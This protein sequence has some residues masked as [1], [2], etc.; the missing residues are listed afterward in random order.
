MNVECG[1]VPGQP[2]S[3]FLY[4]HAKHEAV[5]I[6]LAPEL[7]PAS[8]SIPGAGRAAPLRLLCLAP[9]GVC[10]AA[11]I[12]AS[13]GGLLHR[14]FT[15]TPYSRRMQYTSLLHYAVGLPR[16]SVRQHRCPL[17]SGLSST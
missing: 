3:R 1:K 8:S 2:I 16:L 15:L 10:L 14:R 5:I 9:G 12:T 4:P 17:E 11:D 7:L 13:A 6:S